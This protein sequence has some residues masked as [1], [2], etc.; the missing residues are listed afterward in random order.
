MELGLSNKVIVVSGGA[1]GIGYGI[2]KV[3]AKEGATVCIIGR[4][5]TDN[6]AA[7][8]ALIAAGGKAFGI[9]AELTDPN[10]CKQAIDTVLAT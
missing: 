2:A 6:Q 4:S 7:V 9:E 1:K 10:A 3:L 8:D 5:A